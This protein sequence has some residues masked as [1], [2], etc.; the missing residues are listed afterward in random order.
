MIFKPTKTG[1]RL[2]SGDTPYGSYAVEWNRE[3]QVISQTLNLRE[4]PTG[5]APAKPPGCSGCG[6]ENFQPPSTPDQ[7]EAILR[8]H[9]QPPPEART[10]GNPG[11]PA[12]GYNAPAPEKD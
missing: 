6:G 11:P 2:A 7:A 8:E 3:G 1:G 12:T 9:A 10:P 5:P 4:P